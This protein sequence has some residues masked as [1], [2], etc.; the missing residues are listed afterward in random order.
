LENGRTS[1]ENVSVTFLENPVLVESYC[2]VIQAIW[3]GR[4]S[5]IFSL[6]ISALLCASFVG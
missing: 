2:P 3:I 1:L 6:P 5:Q 4:E